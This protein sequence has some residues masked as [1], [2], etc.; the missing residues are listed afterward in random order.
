MKALRQDVEQEAADELVRLK[1]HHL[2]P[3]QAIRP[4]VL[5]VEGDA[6]PIMGDEPRIRDG[7]P[8]GVARQIGKHCLWPC[9]GPLGVDEPVLS[10][11]RLQCGGA[12]MWWTAPAS[13]IESAIG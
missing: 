1:R 10:A 6:A 11:Q 5:A 9:E 7:H 3:G 2:P 4:V 13:G 8:A 12:L